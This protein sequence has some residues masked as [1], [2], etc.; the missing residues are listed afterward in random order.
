[1]LR[2]TDDHPDD[3][4]MAGAAGVDPGWAD[5]RAIAWITAAPGLRSFALDWFGRR[6]RHDLNARRV[7]DDAPVDLNV[8]PR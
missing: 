6:N 3:Q 1:L 7:Q 2:R 4:G 5:Y 8:P